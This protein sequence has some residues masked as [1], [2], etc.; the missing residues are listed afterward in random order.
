MLTE[1]GD[2][3]QVLAFTLAARYEERWVILFGIL[4]ASLFNHALAA[5]VGTWVGAHLSAG[6]NHLLIGGSFVIFGIWTLWPQREDGVEKKQGG[7]Y[8][9]DTLIFFLAE[10]GDKTQLAT[11]A[12]GA[13]THSPVLVALGATCG[14]FLSDW[15]AV[16]VGERLSQRVPM[17]AVRWVAA[18][19][20]FVLGAVSL[21][22]GR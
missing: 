16:I 6:A 10:M 13:S 20:F 8:F 2:K 17:M 1:M 14:T 9:A 12:M 5:W 7:S 21:T 22:G 4:T 18:F 15:V 3:T 19:L 11:V